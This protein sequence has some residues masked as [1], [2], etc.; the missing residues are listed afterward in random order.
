VVLSSKTATARLVQS[1]TLCPGVRYQFGAWTRQERITA[2]C[3][4]SFYLNGESVGIVAPTFEWSSGIARARTFM[5]SAPEVDLSIDIR[6]S[7]SV[8]ANAVGT[9]ELDDL[10][11]ERVFP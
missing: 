2:Q 5:A 6:C 1:L 10:T 8:S 9:V 11:L 3:E 7:G 4:I